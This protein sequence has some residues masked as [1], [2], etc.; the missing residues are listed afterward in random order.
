MLPDFVSKTKKDIETWGNK[1]TNT[2]NFNFKYEEADKEKD[3]TIISQSVPSGT[4]VKEIIN[5]KK[6]ITIVIAKEKKKDEEE[7]T[8][9]NNDDNKNE[10]MNDKDENN[11]NKDSNQSSNEN[12]NNNND[13]EEDQ[14]KDNNNNEET[15]NEQQFF[16]IHFFT[17]SFII[18]IKNID[19]FT[20]LQY[21]FIVS[22]L[23]KKER[24]KYVRKNKRY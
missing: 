1:F 17:M 24:R 12:T 6:T 10:N 20:K 2:I 11:E 8:D 9:N 22:S 4:S 3:G 13:T 19:F 16:Y 21:T 23:Y 18:H 7:I 15:T 14:K 5:E